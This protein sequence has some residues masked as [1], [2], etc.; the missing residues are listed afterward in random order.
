ML[1]GLEIVRITRVGQDY[2]LHFSDGTYGLFSAEDIEP[3][4]PC[5]GASV[6]QETP[7]TVY[8]N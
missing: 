7:H 4:L 8:L 3:L 1:E 5:F 2:A 6:P